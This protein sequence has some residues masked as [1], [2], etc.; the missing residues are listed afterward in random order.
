M[1]I[2]DS[3]KTVET[4]INSLISKKESDS[5][6]F[7]IINEV[8]FISSDS[9]KKS[10]LVIPMNTTI[11]R[12]RKILGKKFNITWQEVKIVSHKEI[13]D[14][15]NSRTLKEVKLNPNQPLTISRRITSSVNE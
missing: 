4:N 10:D 13:E 5:A 3:E 9:L 11:M 2:N 1:V 6:K 12:L 15:D 8:S 14:Y 7:I